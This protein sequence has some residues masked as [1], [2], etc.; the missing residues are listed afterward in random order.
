MMKLNK[1]TLL[2]SAAKAAILGIA[3]LC[4]LHYAGPKVKNQKTEK[5]TNS[6]MLMLAAMSTNVEIQLFAED[7]KYDFNPAFDSIRTELRNVDGICNFFRKESELAKLNASAS[8][9]PFPCSD[10]LWEILMFSKE[11]YEKTGGAFDISVS[12]LM[13]LWGHYGKQKKLPSP[14]EIAEAKAKCGLDKVIF[15]PEKKT[16]RFTV[17]GMSLNLG[18]IAKGWTLD[19]I[20]KV[21]EEKHGIRKAILNIGGNVLAYGGDFSAGVRNPFEKQN[22]CASVEIRNKA[23]STSG[24]YE[25]FSVIDGKEYSHIIDPRTGYPASEYFS[26]TVVAESGTAS[27]ALSTAC[28]IRGMNLAE[29]LKVDV[30]LIGRDEKDPKLVKAGKRGNS[31]K[32]NLPALIPEKQ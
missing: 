1:K 27:D 26:V 2:R 20:R 29:Q 10:G 15:D 14:A 31:W 12:P 24:G 8:D 22:V 9:A 25:R 5:E 16:V 4:V 11:Y 30:L 17:K 18:G 28:A 7:K 32:L 13:A 23:I 3:V 21:L 19:R 6:A